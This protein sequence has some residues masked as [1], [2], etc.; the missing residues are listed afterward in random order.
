NGMFGA[1]RAAYCVVSKGAPSS[2]RRTPVPPHDTCGR[3]ALR[4]S[5]CC[6]GPGTPRSI[7]EQLDAGLTIRSWMS[8]SRPRYPCPR[9]KASPRN[10]VLDRR[11]GDGAQ[12]SEPPTVKT[13]A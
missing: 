1:R 5:Q 4:V 3:Y 9:C 10:V 6:A 8:A 11:D 7:D 2:R 12:G 13:V